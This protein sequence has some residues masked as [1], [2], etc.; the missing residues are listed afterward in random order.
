[1]QSSGAAPERGPIDTNA[2]VEV[3]NFNTKVDYN[4]TSN[5]STFFR[6]GYFREERDNAKKVN[7]DADGD[8]RYLLTDLNSRNGTYVNGM[9]VATV[10]LKDGDYVQLGESV[11]RFLAGGNLETGYHDEIHRLTLL[12]PLTGVHN[13]RHLYSPRRTCARVERAI[14]SRGQDG[15]ALGIRLQGVGQSD[16]RNAVDVNLRNRTTAIRCDDAAERYDDKELRSIFRSS[17]I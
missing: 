7:L 1:L 17:P 5:I 6:V 16:A 14:H 15:H 4:P 2:T 11:F 12:D 3:R 13:R 10:E 9:R 8:G